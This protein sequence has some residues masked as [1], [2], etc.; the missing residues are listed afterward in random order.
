MGR[1]N[2]QTG[3]FTPKPS[4]VKAS[5]RMQQPPTPLP[6]YRRGTPVEVFIGA[7]WGKG[8]VELSDKNRCTVLLKTGQRRVTCYDARNLR[9]YTSK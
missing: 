7:G 1:F 3:E 6:V 2:K 5:E 9:T 8:T 4:S